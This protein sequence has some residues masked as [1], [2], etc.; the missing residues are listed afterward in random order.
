[1]LPEG[2]PGKYILLA[3]LNGKPAKEDTRSTLGEMRA[4]RKQ[5]EAEGY[6]V[7]VEEGKFPRAAR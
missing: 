4:L 3:L 5:W 2:T 6:T 7:V 1:M